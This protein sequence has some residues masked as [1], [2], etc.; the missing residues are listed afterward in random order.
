[1]E[2]Y[3]FD[4]KE[5]A[6]KTDDHIEGLYDF[7]TKRSILDS[8]LQRRTVTILGLY[9]NPKKRHDLVMDWSALAYIDIQE[10]DS[11]VGV[12]Q[13]SG[14]LPNT[15]LR[16]SYQIYHDVVDAPYGIAYYH[17]T[18]KGPDFYAVGVLAGPMHY[19]ADA[20]AYGTRVA[21][22]FDELRGPRRHL[23]GWFRGVY[24]ANLLSETHLDVV[25]RDN[26]PLR[27]AGLG[28]F[29]QVGHHR[30][31]WELKDSEIPLAEAALAVTGRLI[32]Y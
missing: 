20:L 19:G 16:G 14:E 7:E 9:S 5:Y 6:I 32:C 31:V 22:W 15:L 1:L 26:V 29:S 28:Q 27:E 25:V 18:T 24:P 13:S 11:F 2:R 10:G 3:G 30:W 4:V 23:Q 17:P 12:P 21:K 8:A